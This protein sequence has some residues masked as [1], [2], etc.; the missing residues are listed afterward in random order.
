MTRVAILVDDARRGQFQQ[1]LQAQ[2]EDG[3]IIQLAQAQDGV[4]HEID[5]RDEVEAH[6]RREA[7]T[8]P[9]ADAAIAQQFP[10]QLDVLD[11]LTQAAGAGGRLGIGSHEAA[12]M[13]EAGSAS[14]C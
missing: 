3:Q 9:G 6:E 2:P 12:P 1:Q 11:Q 8:Q 14:T 10:G 5:G 13:S 7:K 4:G